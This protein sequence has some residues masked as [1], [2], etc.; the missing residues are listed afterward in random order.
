MQVDIE[1]KQKP[2]IDSD[3]EE[4]VNKAPK[5]EVLLLKEFI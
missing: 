4:P 3:D 1:T 5:K 2:R